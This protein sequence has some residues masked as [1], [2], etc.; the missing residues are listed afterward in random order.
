MPPRQI[1]RDA[2]RSVQLDDEGWTSR[3][4]RTPVL[5]LTI[6]S[7]RG[8][9]RTDRSLRIQRARQ[10][11]MNS[12]LDV[13]RVSS[14]QLW[15]VSIERNRRC[16]RNSETSSTGWVCSSR[17]ANELRKVRPPNRATGRFARP[18]VAFVWR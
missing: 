2:C 6:V 15:Y 9:C 4:P 7:I 8:A 11:V 5:E 14:S 17:L 12:R 18:K 10:F 3:E 1:Q 16:P 13:E